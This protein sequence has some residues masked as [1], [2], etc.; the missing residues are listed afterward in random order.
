[1][2]NLC[3]QFGLPP[4]TT[5][6]KNRKKSDKGFRKKKNLLH[7]TTV[8]RKENLINELKIFQKPKKKTSKGKCF[9]YGK[10][11]HFADKC[12]DPPKK[13]K[14][15]INA[16]NIDDSE[17]ENIFRIFQNNG[18][19]DYSSDNDYLTSDDSDYHSASEFFENNVKIGC[20]DCCYNNT[21][22]FNVLTKF[23][24]KEDLLITLISK[25]ENAELKE[26]YLKKLKKTMI[27]DINKPV[28]A[29]ISLDET[30][31]RFSQQKSKVITISD[32]LHE[33]SNIKKEIVNLKSDLQIVKTN[34]KYFKQ[35]L[36][37]NL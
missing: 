20:V 2:G 24:E 5:S 8:T 16:L 14:Q 1:M 18:F 11:W 3:E 32:L 23:E 28:G 22:T 35:L 27:K 33:I 36:L 13:I 31:E 25:I 37:L 12:S 21:K 9:N 30:L 4:I 15:E 29:K 34:N 17:K 6:R 7:I 10:S 19:S 26:E